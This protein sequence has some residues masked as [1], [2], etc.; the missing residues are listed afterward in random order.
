MITFVCWR[1]SVPGSRSMYSAESVNTLARMIRRHYPGSH[2]IV[3]VTNDHAG[4]VPSIDI[5]PDREDFANVPSPHGAG[6]P[7]CYRRLRLFE[8]DAGLT[9]GDRIVS[10]DLDCVITGD[11]SS[12]FEFR[13]E[14]VVGW[15]DPLYPN[16]LNGSLLLL[17][18]GSRSLVWEEFEPAK[19]PRFTHDLGY[20]G[21][22]QAWLSHWLREEPRWTRAD[23]VYSYRVDRCA[24]QLPPDARIVFFHGRTKPWD[25][26]AKR[27]PW[28]RYHYQ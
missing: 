17:R 8:R 23:G 11:L 5:I 2:R 6:A 9:F 21:S 1:W 19:S 14:D 13:A 27:L 7:S 25:A 22:D 16:Q 24:M 15:Q 4:I 28:V 20:R 18:A 12:L 10:I 3:C 26:E